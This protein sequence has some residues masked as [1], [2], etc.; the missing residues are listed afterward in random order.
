M[1]NQLLPIAQEIHKLFY[2]QRLQWEEISNIVKIPI[3]ST[4]EFFVESICNGFEYDWN[5]LAISEDIEKTTLEYVSNMSFDHTSSTDENCN[6]IQRIFE[7]IQKVH[8]NI[9]LFDIK[10]ILVHTW[11]KMHNSQS[12]NTLHNVADI[13]N[14]NCSQDSS[15]SE[16]KTNDSKI[17]KMCDYVQLSANFLHTKSELETK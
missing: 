1:Q 16:Q 11:R 8:P 17:L 7:H 13:T 6:C 15:C 5:Q 10:A 4:Q 3:E 12:I 2:H 14:Q 9:T